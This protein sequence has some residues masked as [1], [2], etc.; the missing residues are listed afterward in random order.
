MYP[1]WSETTKMNNN[2]CDKGKGKTA[3][4]I[5]WETFYD[6]GVMD[7]GTQKEYIIGQ[8]FPEVLK[9]RP[10]GKISQ[11]CTIWYPLC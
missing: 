1:T 2:Y 3:T 5:L 7:N 9:S 11:H 10:R 4:Y 8:M 6:Q